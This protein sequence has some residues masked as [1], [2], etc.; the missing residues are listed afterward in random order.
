MG[1]PLQ[2]CRILVAGYLGLRSQARPSPG[3]NIAGLQPSTGR[4][5]R[6]RQRDWIEEAEGVLSL[7]GSVGREPKRDVAQSNRLGHEDRLDPTFKRAAEGA[8]VSLIG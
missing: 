5:P 7:D 6:E 1:P 8:A 3:Y 4:S 2:G